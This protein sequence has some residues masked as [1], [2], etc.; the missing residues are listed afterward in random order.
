M[1]GRVCRSQP[2][3]RD[4]SREVRSAKKFRAQQG[5]FLSPFAPYGYVKDPD[6]KNRLVIDP[7]A[8][9]TVRRIFQLTADGNNSEQIATVLN[10]EAVPMPMLYKRAA[11][12]S[13]TRWPSVWEDNF[14]TGSAVAKILRDERYI[15]K[16]VYGK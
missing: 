2:G 10:R 11:S 15:G 7:D 6:N 12:C 9:E 1:S 4:L 3:S 14:W 5:D 13:R 8:A 16:N